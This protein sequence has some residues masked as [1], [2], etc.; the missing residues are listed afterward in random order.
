MTKEKFIRIHA[1]RGY[2]IEDLGKIVIISLNNYTAT[3]F[4]NSDGSLDE[5]N[6]ATW[7]IRH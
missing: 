6:P 7:N 4:F 5:K 3:W 1:H 2:E